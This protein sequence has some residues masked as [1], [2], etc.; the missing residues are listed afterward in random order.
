VTRPRGQDPAGLAG[1]GR[2]LHSP[3]RVYGLCGCVADVEEPGVVV[4]DDGSLA[5]DDCYLYSVCSHCCTVGGSLSGDCAAGHAHGPGLPVCPARA[6]AG[7]GL[8]AAW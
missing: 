5:C 3:W 7:E 6:I 4:L 2:W 8:E 1:R